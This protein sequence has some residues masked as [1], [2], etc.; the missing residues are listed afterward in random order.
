MKKWR[1]ETE[2]EKG[3]R[4]RKCHDASLFPFY[5]RGRGPWPSSPDTGFGGQHKPGS[6]PELYV[7]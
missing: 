6:V 4:A 3:D 2:E 5:I 7:Q 1:R